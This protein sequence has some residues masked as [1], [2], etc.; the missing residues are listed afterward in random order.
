MNRFFVKLFMNSNIDVVHY[1]QSEAFSVMYEYFRQNMV[2]P[3]TSLTNR[4]L[5]R[6]LCL[7][8]KQKSVV[9]SDIIM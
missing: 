4:E 7:W 9:Q 6:E 3:V 2:V 5:S 1:C 8:I